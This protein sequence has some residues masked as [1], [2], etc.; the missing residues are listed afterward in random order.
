MQLVETT[1]A[2]RDLIHGPHPAANSANSGSRNVS[3][4]ISPSSEEKYNPRKRDPQY[5]HAESACLWE[6]VRIALPPSETG[7]I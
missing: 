5:A 2:L 3:G 1:P 4:D 7:F 6:L